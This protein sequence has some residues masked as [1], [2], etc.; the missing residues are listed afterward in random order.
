MFLPGNVF[1][2]SIMFVGKARSLLWSGTPER[3]FTQI[4]Y[5]LTS[6]HVTRLERPD[7][8][9]GTNTLY[10][11]YYQ[12]SLIKAVKSFITLCLG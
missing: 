11:A 8:V 10:R 5:S 7:R 1:Q 6:K 9:K 12:H 4:R 2:L 3:C